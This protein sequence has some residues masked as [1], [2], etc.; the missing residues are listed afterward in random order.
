MKIDREAVLKILNRLLEQ[1]EE[2]EAQ[3]GVAPTAQEALV[4]A[5]NEIYALESTSK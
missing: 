2:V 3:V 1:A 4:W 5:I